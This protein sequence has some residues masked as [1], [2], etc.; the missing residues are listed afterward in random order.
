L[1]SYGYNLVHT[2]YS[3]GND[4]GYSPRV[5]NTKVVGFNIIVVANQ[6]SGYLAINTLNHRYRLEPSCLKGLSATFKAP[7]D[8]SV[9]PEIDWSA[10]MK[11]RQI[12]Y[13]H[14]AQVRDPIPF[15][16]WERLLPQFHIHSGFWFRAEGNTVSVHLRLH[17]SFW[18]SEGGENVSDHYLVGFGLVDKSLGFGPCFRMGEDLGWNFSA[19]ALHG[20]GGG[21]KFTLDYFFSLSC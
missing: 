15:T 4:K 1:R 3:F 8:M 20:V 6:S 9:R 11:S 18:F 16:P 12:P 21:G 13:N 7:I 10:L 5:V 14:M 17:S 19:A 2:T